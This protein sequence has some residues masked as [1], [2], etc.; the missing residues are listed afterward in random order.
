MLKKLNHE[1][2]AYFIRNNHYLP[3]HHLIPHH[4]LHKAHALGL[5]EW[6]HDLIKTGLQ[7]H[8]IFKFVK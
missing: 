2:C 7:K 3:H 8:L 5:T 4:Y 6:N 1:E